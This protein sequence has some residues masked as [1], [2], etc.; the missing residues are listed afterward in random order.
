MNAFLVIVSL[1]SYAPSI[2]QLAKEGL[3]SFISKPLSLRKN[4]TKTL[5]YPQ[6]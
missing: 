1:S 2:T 4:L 6:V 3:D 5:A